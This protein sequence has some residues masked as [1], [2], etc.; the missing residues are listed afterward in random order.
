[1]PYGRDPN[2]GF[3]RTCGRCGERYTDQAAHERFHIDRPDDDHMTVK[4]VAAAVGR[5]KSVVK[6]WIK[7]RKLPA[8]YTTIAGT[9]R[10]WVKRHALRDFVASAM[11]GDFRK[12]VTW[13]A[14]GRAV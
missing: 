13:A 6:H 4:E 11:E 1:M 9:R 3:W 10:V 12:A 2:L 8:V 7:T 14:T 5:Q